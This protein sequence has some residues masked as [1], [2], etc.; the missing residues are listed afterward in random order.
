MSDGYD[1][2]AWIGQRLDSIR[3]LDEKILLREVLEEVFTGLYD[4]TERKYKALED[5]VRSELAFEQ[6]R[7][8]VYTGLLEQERLD[9]SHPYLFPLVPEDLELPKTLDELQAAIAKGRPLLATAFLKA[10]YLLCRTLA[11]ETRTWP[12]SLLTSEGEFSIRVRLTPAVRH[13]SR[14]EALYRLF[15]FHQLQWVTVNAPYLFKLFD[16]EL[17]DG[18]QLPFQKPARI[19]GIRLDCGQY[20]EYLRYGLLPV[21]NIQS[22]RLKGEDFPVP[23]M[24]KVNYEYRFD[25]SEEGEEHGYL[26]EQGA[27]IV[28]A[29]RESGSLVVTSPKDKGLEWTLCKVWQR[30]DYSI[31]VMEYPIV[32]N[33][34]RDS[35]AGR[36][37]AHYGVVIKT[38]AELE[39]LIHSYEAAEGLRFLE[40]RI[41]DGKV[42]GETYE[43]NR[44]IHDEIRSG[45]YTKTM[46]LRFSALQ[47]GDYLARD[48]MSYLTAQIQLA[49]PEYY[50]T[51]VLE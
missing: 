29:R 49:Y 19:T 30:K 25:L 45:A 27:E 14:V 5:R 51:G 7:Y 2:K 23:A 26:V 6:N 20:T 41:V 36:L 28:A 44:F 16:M 32:S 13:L 43:P 47:R 33:R 10:D 40:Y 48:R 39:R 24:D 3:D 12:G 34:Q 11:Q 21:W 1:M 46:L 18:T 50:C 15:L 35:F 37:A 22:R 38:R 42:D 17:I 8:V 9:G 4:E 31:D